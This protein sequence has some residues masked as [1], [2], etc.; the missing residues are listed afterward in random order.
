M[1]HARQAR[2]VSLRAVALGAAAL[3]VAIALAATVGWLYAR[4]L[5]ASGS[6]GAPAPAA[7]AASAPAALPLSESAPQPERAR[8]EAEKLAELN[9]WGWIDKR[10]GTA[11]IPVAR[12]MALMADER[13]EPAP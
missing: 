4:R 9:G 3:A 7:P 11:R 1:S 8:Y 10:A 2:N 6:L 5:N 12:A 13:K